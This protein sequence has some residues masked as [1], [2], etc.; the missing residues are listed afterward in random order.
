M[1]D[2]VVVLVDELE[3][4]P[5]DEVVFTSVLVLLLLELEPPAG[6]GFT[7]VVLFSVLLPGEAAGVTV[8]VLCSH[9]ARSAALAMMQMYFFIS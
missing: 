9:E 6:D 4:V 3:L 7:I 5:G 1:A 8:S 2:A